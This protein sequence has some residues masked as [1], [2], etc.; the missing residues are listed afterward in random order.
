ML[1]Y[2]GVDDIIVT[3]GVFF[4]PDADGGNSA[5]QWRTSFEVNVRGGYLVAQGA[6]P[7]FA[8]AGTGR[9]TGF[10]D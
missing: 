4:T 7:I 2:G 1:A 10:D 3:A 8:G 6:R 9:F 5:E